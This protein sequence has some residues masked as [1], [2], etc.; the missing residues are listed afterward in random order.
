MQVDPSNPDTVLWLQQSLHRVLPGRVSVDLNG[1]YDHMTEKMVG[2]FQGQNGLPVTG[3]ADA[4]TIAKIE[5]E[6]AILDN[7]PFKK[8]QLSRPSFRPGD[9]IP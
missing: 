2:R 6:L 3:Q 7:Q 5:Q 4:A 1:Q 9:P 8:K